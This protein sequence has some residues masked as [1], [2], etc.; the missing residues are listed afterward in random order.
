MYEGD[1]DVVYLKEK[2]GSGYY[3][4]FDFLSTSRY[5]E[6]KECLPP[7]NDPGS[8]IIRL[9]GDPVSWKLTVHGIEHYEREAEKE[10]PNRSSINVSASNSAVSIHSPGAMQSVRINQEDLTPEILELLNELKTAIENRDEEKK[11]LLLQKLK[12]GSESVF[13]NL[14]ASGLF[15]LIQPK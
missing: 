2:F 1:G 14:I 6:P 10:T 8:G 5:I 7:R 11:G 12:N 3:E 13:W 9:S 4:I 15:A